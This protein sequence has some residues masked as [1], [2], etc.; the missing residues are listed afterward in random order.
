MPFLL[1]TN[2]EHAKANTDTRINPE[3]KKANDFKILFEDI[4]LN[5]FCHLPDLIIQRGKCR[6]K[7]AYIRNIP[8]LNTKRNPS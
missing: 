8:P 3:T 7:P 6:L 5:N 1:S 4:T 2:A